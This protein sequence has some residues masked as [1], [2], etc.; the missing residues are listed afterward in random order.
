VHGHESVVGLQG[1]LVTGQLS[2]LTVQR[3]PGLDRMLGN[4]LA[5]SLAAPLAPLTSPL[6]TGGAIFAL[7]AACQI[8]ISLTPLETVPLL[9]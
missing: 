3:K 2:H 6:S 9:S 4:A 8:L 1:Q 7:P 5:K